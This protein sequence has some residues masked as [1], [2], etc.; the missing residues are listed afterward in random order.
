MIQFVND[1]KTSMGCR[2]EKAPSKR[3]FWHN[4]ALFAPEL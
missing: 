1:L 4:S 2:R 3:G